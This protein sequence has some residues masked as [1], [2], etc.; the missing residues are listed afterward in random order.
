MSDE[1]ES[2]SEEEEDNEVLS[3]EEED[4]DADS[5]SSTAGDEDKMSAPATS[6]SEG[7]ENEEEGDGIADE[8][9]DGQQREVREASR[10]EV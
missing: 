2:S 6:G 8:G 4:N 7:I 9:D 1:G 3:E 5:A 10:I